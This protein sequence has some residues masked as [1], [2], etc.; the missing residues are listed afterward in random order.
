MLTLKEYAKRV[1][2]AVLIIA[3]TII[4]PY[5]IYRLFPHFIPF[6]LAYLTALLLE[7]L[8]LWFMRKLK[9]QKAL[10]T[11]ITFSLFLGSVALILYLIVNK[12]YVQLIGLLR[13]IESNSPEI[14][15]WFVQF[16]AQIQ[17]TISLL[18]SE[19]A[20]QVNQMISNSINALGNINLVAKVG[21]YT[22]S[23]TTAIP[24]ML[25][26]TLI[27]FIAVFMFIYQLENIHNRFYSFFKDSTKRKVLFVLS[28]LRRA[29]F[30]FLKAQVILS[31]VTFLMAFIGLLILKVR[32][33][34][35]I[36]LLIT[37][38]DI[39]PI[40][41]TGSFLM[42]W[43]AI[44]LF[45]GNFFLAIGLVVLFFVIAIVRKTIEPKV[46]GERIGLGAL[47]TLISIWV[48]FKV[49]GVLGVFLFPVICILY[50]ALVKVGVIK[51]HKLKF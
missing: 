47:T 13:Y 18:P 48:G 23:I 7:P 14:Q 36:A 4:I 26:L 46:L 6:I 16:A 49:M 19:T 41:G 8:N 37:L 39:L 24:N 31:T 22:Y 38:V 34:A 2:V 29:T 44:S 33:T 20:N 28:D 11:S 35:L 25:F 45:R 3:A 42:P 30:G 15:S 17:D 1:F 43:A 10:S 51:I 9:L 27:Y 50:Q 12:I 40:L 32:Y 5:I 21:S